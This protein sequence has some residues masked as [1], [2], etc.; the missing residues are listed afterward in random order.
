MVNF[1]TNILQNRR[2][3]FNNNTKKCIYLKSWHRNDHLIYLRCLSLY[4]VDLLQHM[5]MLSAFKCLSCCSLWLS[6]FNKEAPFFLFKLSCLHFDE[7][8]ISLRFSVV[9]SW[10]SL[11]V[12][13][14]KLC[15]FGHCFSHFCKIGDIL[16]VISCTSTSCYSDSDFAALQFSTIFTFV[17][18]YIFSCIVFLC[19]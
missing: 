9:C 4:F 13:T 14:L 15:S 3:F 6:T 7:L 10:L 1:Y 8:L 16:V 5:L 12:N 19:K 11:H 2:D 18:I 17:K